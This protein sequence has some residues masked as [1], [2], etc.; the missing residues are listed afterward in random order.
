MRSQELRATSYELGARG[1][2]PLRAGISLMEVLISIGIMA[3]GMLS[4]ASLLPVGNV[5]V[6]RANTEERK[7]EL[8]LNAYREFQV[9][10][11]SNPANWTKANGSTVTLAKYDPTTGTFSPARDDWNTPPLAIDPLMVAVGTTAVD[12]FPAT[13]VSGPSMKRLG[14]SFASSR[15]LAEAVFTLTNELVTIQPDDR[16]SPAQFPSSTDLPEAAQ[17]RPFE[18]NYTWLATLTPALYDP[19]SV[20]AATGKDYTL[21]I[22]IFANRRLQSTPDEYQ[23]TATSAVTTGIDVG[24]GDFTFSDASSAK[25]DAVKANQWIML[26]RNEPWSKPNAAGVMTPQ[27][28]RPVFKWY[29][30]SSFGDQSFASG[31]YSMDV[32]LIGPDWNNGITGTI[33]ACIFDGAVGVYQRTIHLEDPSSIWNQ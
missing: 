32:S 33:Y 10:G 22:V 30:V 23:V 9:R 29:R 14:L 5:Q 17:R 25:L 8:G 16:T 21:S 12:T 1:P 18:G 2:S 13:T 7:A 11:M 24:G 19:D 4:I 28:P 27:A 26:C 15:P 20:T 3:I 6:Q 31:K